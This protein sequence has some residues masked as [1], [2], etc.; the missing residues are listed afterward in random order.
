MSED[1]MEIDGFDFDPNSET[2]WIELD[3]ILKAND[4]SSSINVIQMKPTPPPSSSGR[5]NSSPFTSA[6]RILFQNSSSSRLINAPAAE[7]STTA[8]NSGHSDTVFLSTIQNNQ[9]S[10][11]KTSKALGFIS[12]A[13]SRLIPWRY[14]FL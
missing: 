8:D 3:A 12:S 7:I 2:Q 4:S 1:A 11:S 14:A 6:L 10:Q 9:A 13:A 5:S